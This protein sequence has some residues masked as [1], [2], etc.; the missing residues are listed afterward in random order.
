MIGQFCFCAESGVLFNNECSHCLLIVIIQ[1][2]KKFLICV[3]G[4]GVASAAFAQTPEAPVRVENR[5]LFDGQTATAEKKEKA[6]EDREVAIEKQKEFRAEVKEQKVDLMEKRQDFTDANAKARVEFK[7]GADAKKTEV[8]A[9]LDAATTEE[10]RRVVRDRATEEKKAMQAERE[11]YRSDRK[12]KAQSFIAERAGL[13]VRKVQ[14]GID[15]GDQI[16]ERLRTVAGEDTSSVQT[17][18]DAYD[19]KRTRAVSAL[20]EAQ[21][22]INTA[23]SAEEAREAREALGLAKD[24][25]KDASAAIKE[26]YS[27]LR[28]TFT[29]LKA[30]RAEAREA[31]NEEAT[32]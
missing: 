5:A 21:T 17:Y 14:A 6:M 15:R 8:R 25:F 10:E 12:V 22:H 16:F 19:T 1:I 20:A 18:F 30:M 24:S 11:E 7:S 23:V 13:V 2:M 26:M 4:L 3:V 29:T 31:I 32:N 28:S 27:S 9:E